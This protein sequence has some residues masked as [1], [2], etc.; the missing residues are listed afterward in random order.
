VGAITIAIC[1]AIM[2][3]QPLYLPG[4]PRS[5][6]KVLG[7]ILGAGAVFAFL[8]LLTRKTTWVAAAERSKDWSIVTLGHYL[9][10]NY[11]LIFESAARTGPS[12][13]WAIIY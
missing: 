9:L 3:S 12:S 11:V 13:P 10:T 4:P 7:A 2:L 8:A 1:F 6:L 5:L